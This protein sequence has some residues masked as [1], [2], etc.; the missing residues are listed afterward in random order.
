MELA[1]SYRLYLSWHVLLLILLPPRFCR[2]HSAQPALE[3]YRLRG[4]GG[5]E[6]VVA[7]GP[8]EPVKEANLF[9]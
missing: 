8:K 4:N 2:C 5:C 7:L 1:N 9:C 6:K 3:G